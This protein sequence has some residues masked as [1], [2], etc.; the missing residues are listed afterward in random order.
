MECYTSTVESL[1][2]HTTLGFSGIFDDAISALET[3]PKSVFLVEIIIV[4]EYPSDIGSC[5]SKIEI[6]SFFLLIKII[7][8]F[9]PLNFYVSN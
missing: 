3:L 6:I 1:S 9:F 7:V 5:L 4:H 2:Q 8:F